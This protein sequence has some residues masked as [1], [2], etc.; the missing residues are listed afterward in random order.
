MFK[1][2][3]KSDPNSQLQAI[4]AIHHPHRGAAL[5]GCRLA[6]YQTVATAMREAGHLARSMSYKAAI[7]NLPFTGGKTVLLAPTKLT[8][9]TKYFQSLGKFINELEG[10]YIAA[11]DSGVTEQ[12]M[13]EVAK[14][15]SYVTNF[16]NV[17]GDPSPDTAKGVKIAIET[18]VNLFLNKTDLT[19]LHIV[20]QGVG[21]VGYALVKEL[22]N[23]NTRL[24]IIDKNPQAIAHCLE[25][26]SV[27]VI[28]YRNINTLECDIFVP[29]AM[30]GILNKEFAT[31]VRT[32]IIAGAA[33]NQLYSAEIGYLL[34]S[35]NIF[36]AP[37]YAI[38]AGG[39][40]RCASQYL[41]KSEQWVEEKIT[42]I[43]SLLFQVF[44]QARRL[45]L[46]TNIVADKMA[47]DLM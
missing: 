41:G 13:D 26:F 11:V 15:T 33:N 18:A 1:F 44:E 35:R 39:L 7:H 9:R 37:D 38:N 20:I 8:A 12:D 10:Q 45:N 4:I 42:N 5:G 25:K 19:N 16:S 43:K 27:E 31:T 6:S 22:Y 23:K 30:G 14:Y 34:Q 3:Q 40:I 21:N 17:G 47:K 29:C 28:D 2:H 24:T 32:K 36:Y 46:P